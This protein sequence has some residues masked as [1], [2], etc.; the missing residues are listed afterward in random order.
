MEKL[1]FDLRIYKE[2]EVVYETDSY[3]RLAI[4]GALMDGDVQVSLKVVEDYI[5][6]VYELWL[7]LE[8]YDSVFTI[9][10][11]V[12]EHYDEIK[13]KNK[14]EKIGAYYNWLDRK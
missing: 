2:E 7:K 11:F 4:F 14:N 8:S 5:E 3:V 12:K 13:G 9:A 10:D 6:E 1:V